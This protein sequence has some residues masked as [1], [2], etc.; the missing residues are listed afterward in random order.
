VIDD[1]IATPAD[2]ASMPKIPAFS[3]AQPGQDPAPPSGNADSPR[4]RAS[5]TGCAT[6][7]R[8]SASAKVAGGRGSK[9]GPAGAPSSSR[10]SRRRFVA[11]I[12]PDVTVPLRTLAGITLPAR[13]A[14]FVTEKFKEPFAY[15]QFDTPMYKPLPNLVGAVLAQPEPDRAEQ[16]YAARDAPGVHRGVHGGLNHE[17]ARELLW[18]E[19][20]PT[21]AGATSGSSGDVSAFLDPKPK[22]DPEE[23][24]EETAR[25][26][27]AHEWLLRRS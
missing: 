27:E 20:R 22:A 9:E 10:R 6:C 13:L 14:R 5:R 23:Q 24:K 15:P 12:N 4:G 11:S 8:S 26:H 1:D 17:F 18:R 16:H 7:E 19:Y 21:S 3:V 25:Y 2:V